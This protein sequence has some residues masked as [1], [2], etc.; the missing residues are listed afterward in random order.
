MRG[1]QSKVGFTLSYKS[2]EGLIN[3]GDTRNSGCIPGYAHDR[4]RSRSYCSP[5]LQLE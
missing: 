3:R 5:R 2:V 1:S 4:V